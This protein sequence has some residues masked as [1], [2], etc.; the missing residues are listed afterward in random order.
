MK[1][2]WKE[3]QEY[4]D[5][6]F[7]I[8][9]LVAHFKISTKSIHLAK[10]R[11]EFVTRS[12]SESALL[13]KKK[14]GKK[15]LS[16]SHKDNISNGM[17]DAHRNGNAWNIGQSR[18]NNE[19]SWPEQFFMNVVANEFEDKNYEYEKPFHKF[20]L[21]FVWEHKKKV[22]EIDGEQHDRCSEQRRRDEEKDSLLEQNGYEILRI[23][24]KDMFNNPKVYIKLAKDFI[25]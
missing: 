12:K 10:K 5:K 18:W 19:P 17:K 11:G 22:I 20:S 14:F 6:G 15:V 9:E 21:D 13:V 24:W 23:K 3:I 1:N 25:N 2:N 7:S 16:K 8:R 4:Y